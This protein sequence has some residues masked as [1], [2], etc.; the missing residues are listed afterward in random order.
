MTRLFDLRSPV[1]PV[2]VLAVSLSLAGCSSPGSPGTSADGGASPDTEATTE[3]TSEATSGDTTVGPWEECPGIL[4]SLNGNE[5]DPTV[6]EE[7]DPTD[8]GVQEVGAD[9]L[10]S[11]CV[12]GVTIGEDYRTWAILPGD[13]SLAASIKSDLADAGFVSGGAIPGMLGNPGT[14]QGVLVSSFATGAGLDAY[15]VYTTAFT[16]IDEPIIYLGAFP[17]S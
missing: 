8:F 16:S 4:A 15:L 5:N 7:I 6:Y 2:L 17:L 1:V 11:S 10:A 12:I 9:V 3:A 13:D 14:G